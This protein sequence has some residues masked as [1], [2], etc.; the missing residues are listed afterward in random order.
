MSMNG[1]FLLKLGQ[2]TSGRMTEENY[3]TSFSNH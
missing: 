3:T 2:L 1:Q